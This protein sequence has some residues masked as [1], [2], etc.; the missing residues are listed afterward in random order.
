MGACGG[1][2][3]IGMDNK[4]HG[5]A[6][7]RRLYRVLGGGGEAFIPDR[8]FGIIIKIIAEF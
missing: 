7:A 8:V 2:A 6:S 5:V 1:F 3:D 4:A